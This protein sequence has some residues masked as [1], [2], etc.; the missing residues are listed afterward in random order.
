MDMNWRIIRVAA[1][2]TAT[3]LARSALIH[4]DVVDDVEIVI[5]ETTTAMKSTTSW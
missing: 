3:G 2:L 1:N 4:N 5:D